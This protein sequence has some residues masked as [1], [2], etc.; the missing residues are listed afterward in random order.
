MDFEEILDAWEK[1]QAGLSSTQRQDMEELISRYPPKEP[2]ESDQ[3]GT[4]H[5][6]ERRQNARGQEP[7]ASLD[8]HGMNSREAEQA[9]ENFI[10][11]ARRKSLRRILIIHGKGRHSPAEP[12]LQRVVRRYLEKCPY[13]GAFGPAG[14]EHGGR[15]ATWVNVRN[16]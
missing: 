16:S 1:K 6:N 2:K 7:Q 15:G 10:H 8:L 5:H 14:R 13:T 3:G 11:L 12:V 9:L 4:K